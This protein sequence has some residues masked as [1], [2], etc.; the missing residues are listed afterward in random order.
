MHLKH[1][2]SIATVV[3]CAMLSTG[4]AHGAVGSG[5]VLTENSSTSL[6]ASLSSGLPGLTVTVTYSGTPDLWTLTFNAPVTGAAEWLEP[7]GISLNDVQLTVGT[8]DSLTVRSDVRLAA[9]IGNGGTS[10]SF[11]LDNAL[12]EVTFNDNGDGV[13][14]AT[15]TLPLLSLSLAGLAIL[16]KR[17]KAPA[18]PS[19]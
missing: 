11:T 5:L 1:T 3:V 15:S 14:D 17:I 18:R 12:L 9:P 10:D 19:H 2:I 13:P 4:I 7:D 16:A 8:T 6:S